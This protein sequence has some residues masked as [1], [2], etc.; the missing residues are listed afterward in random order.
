[1][2]HFFAVLACHLS[3]GIEIM[4]QNSVAQ[5]FRFRHFVMRSI[6]R[7]LASR[8]SRSRLGGL[9]ML[10]HSLAQTAIYA[11]VLSSVMAS[12]LPGI[13]NR[14]GYAIYL[15]AGMLCWTLFAEVVTRGMTVFIDNAELIK[16]M[17]FPHL[18]L[19]LIA[20]GVAV[21]GYLM[22]LAAT[23]LIFALLGH[24]A[25]AQL[26]WLLP[27]TLLTL[28]VAGALGLLVGVINVFVRD[29]GQLMTIVIQLLFWFTPVIYH[30]EILPQVLQSLVQFSPIF[31]LVEMY[32]AVLVY[33]EPPALT[34]LLITSAYAVG[35]GGLALFV[36][37]R[38]A[39]DI[40]DVV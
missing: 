25:W 30:V 28:L 8:F 27:L 19:P 40:A 5:L 17:D 35:L 29:I 12:R 33:A 32:H 2:A 10:F 13:D 31:H 21:A 7:E 37:S 16:K 34:G 11:F 22:L 15:L 1:M 38:A 23:L 36:Y 6:Q 39:N 20:L 9:W 18:A 3:R 26:P 4:R 24:L 14:F